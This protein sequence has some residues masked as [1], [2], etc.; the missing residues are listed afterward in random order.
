M[1]AKRADRVGN[2][3]KRSEDWRIHQNEARNAR[4][5]SLAESINDTARMA[6]TTL[7]LALLVALYLG[8]T[9]LSSTD[10]NLFLNGQVVLPQVGTGVSVV[11]SYIFAPPVF[12][13]LHVQA[14]FM[15]GVLARKV[16]AYDKAL[17]GEQVPED[18]RDEY[19]DWL[20][21][22]AFVQ[23]FRREHVLAHPSRLLSWLGTNV[24]P[25][26]LLFAIDVSFVR[27]QSESIT[28]FHHGLFIGDLIFVA[29]FNWQ[30]FKG[31]PFVWWDRTGGVLWRLL[32]RRKR[33]KWA[34]PLY[35]VGL[36][37]IGAMQGVAIAM[38]LILVFH[39][40]APWYDPDTVEQDRQRIHRQSSLPTELPPDEQVPIEQQAE[41]VWNALTALWDKIEKREKGFNL[42]D[43]GPCEWWGAGCRYLDVGGETLVEETAE[44]RF[45]LT[46]KEA[47]E[48]EVTGLRREYS[49]PLL[50]ARRNFRFADFDGVFAPSINLQGSDL[51]GSIAKP[52]P[53][54]DDRADFT[55][56][57]LKLASLDGADWNRVLLNQA[58]LTGA[59]ANRATFLDARMKDA[60][61]G[62]VYPSGEKPE[63]RQCAQLQGADLWQARRVA[64]GMDERSTVR[65][66]SLDGQAGGRHAASACRT[67]AF[68][69]PHR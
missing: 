2:R 1:L 34:D 21:A 46:L 55:G 60:G 30:V 61:I 66:R 8:V 42:L 57:N 22:F 56:A 4:L 24:V 50:A 23:L 69:P 58:V 17:A 25:L 18:R 12:V 31:G 32:S 44:S 10:L 39:A 28:W 53:N 51:R 16:R 40:Q 19:W 38:A 49:T 11:Q 52:W 45:R 3:R 7:T 65:L 29:G 27:Y 9:L 63:L 35:W 5:R 26:G 47:A 13:F 48:D 37:W 41:E 64:A 6:R 36:V 67:N 33:L 68:H 15:L 54:G 59:H 43:A 20:S 14:L 62:C